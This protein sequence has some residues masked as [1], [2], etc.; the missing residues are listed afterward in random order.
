MPY[1]YV[2]PPRL[3]PLHDEDVV[4]VSNLPAERKET[5]RLKYKLLSSRCD[6]MGLRFDYYVATARD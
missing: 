2:D 4:F 1:P 6:R 5:Q 3:F